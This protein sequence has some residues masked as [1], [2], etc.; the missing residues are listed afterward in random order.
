MLELDIRTLLA[1]IALVSLVCSAALI[2]LWR[3]Q[4]RRNGAGFWAAGM[5]FVAIA[6]IL[7]TGRE[8]IPDILSLVLT[9]VFYVMGF[10][11][12]LRGI[13][14]FADR[15]P[16]VFF[17]FYLPSITMAL[18]CYFTYID[19][20][21]DARIVVLSVAFMSI[22]FTIAYTLFNQKKV[23]W[24]TAGRFVALVFG[25]FG[26]L[27]GLRGI[28]AIISP[29][30]TSLFH[31]SHST[32]LVFL[33]SIFILVA[34]TISL[35]M[36]TYAVLES[37]LRILSHAVNQ[38][39]SSILITN[40]DGEIEYVNPAC[41]GKTGYSEE[42]LIGANPRLL[43]SGKA[44]PAEYRLLWKKLIG[45]ETWRGEFH[46]RKKNGELFWEIGSIAPVKQ[47]NG[48]ITHYVAMKEDI[49]A[50]KMAEKRILHMANHDPLTGLPTRRLFMD[51]LVNN[52]AF[53]KRYNTIVAIL[54]IDLDG[55]KAVND[56]LSHEGGDHILKEV[57][58]RITACIRDVDTVSRVGG[59]EFMVILTNMPD[60]NS[61]VI[62][63]EKLVKAI[64]APYQFESADNITIG[65]SIGIA[66]YPDNGHKPS[67]LVNLADLSM[68]KVKRQGKNN[69]AFVNERDAF[70]LA[71]IIKKRSYVKRL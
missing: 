34:S 54:Y 23:T 10:A 60:K 57:S 59:D 14:V 17:D 25:L 48:V 30:D 5:S 58:S 31:S 42:E 13:R 67:E 70:D 62:I 6:S 37:E 28:I 51:R 21:L 56:S 52:L 20:N 24:Q 11:L 38:S 12:I 9:N 71:E 26:F 41:I 61:I 53:A 40:T 55:F 4:S 35:F 8:Y 66:L 33:G 27:H 29:S 2:A 44:N 3:S 36:L 49:T 65:A 64:S 22:C 43:R 15:S 63:A 1:V 50:L 39:A 45:G 47:K 16:L 69:Y 18:F 32:S 19:N 68:Y 46:N 7:I